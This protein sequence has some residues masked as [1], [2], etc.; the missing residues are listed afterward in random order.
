MLFHS[1]TTAIAVP[2]AGPLNGEDML[3][4]TDHTT[5][6]TSGGELLHVVASPATPGH[7]RA[8]AR[9]RSPQRLRIST[10]AANF[11]ECLTAPATEGHSSLPCDLIAGVPPEC[12]RGLYPNTCGQ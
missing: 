4:G 9:S 3:R 5:D 10:F 6:V 8:F 1:G 7:R 11:Q 12:L 2:S